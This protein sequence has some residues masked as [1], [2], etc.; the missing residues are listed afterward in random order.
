[1]FQGKRPLRTASPSCG[2]AEEVELNVNVQLTQK[3]STVFQ[4]LPQ[5]RTKLIGLEAREKG[6]VS[7]EKAVKNLFQ[8]TISGHLVQKKKSRVADIQFTQKL[9]LHVADIHN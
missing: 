6:G 7:G 4:R 1:M 9:F 8:S 2:R 5:E 3:K